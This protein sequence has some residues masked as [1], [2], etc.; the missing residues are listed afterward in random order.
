MS[1][2]MRV[3]GF[4]TVLVLAGSGAAFAQPGGFLSGTDITF[5]SGASVQPIYDGWTKNPDGSYQMHFGY[6]N[7]NYV[8]QPSVPIGAQNSIEPGGPDRGQPTFFYPRYNRRVFSLTVPRDFG[9]KGEVTWTLTVNGKTE[10]AVGWLQP[11]W[12][13]EAQSGRDPVMNAKNKPPSI[14]VAAPAGPVNAGASLTLTAK[15]T[16]DGLPPAGKTRVG[17]TSENPPAFRPENAGVAPTNVP[18][19]QRQR[20]PRING[21]SVSWRVFRGP[22]PVVFEPAAVAVKDGQ[23]VVNATFKTP[24][25]YVLRAVA[26]DTLATTPFDVKVVVTAAGGSAQGQQ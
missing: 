1:V 2:P 26:N 14:T 10:K 12:E 25:E 8:Q 13:I 3:V 5:N 20:V 17:G 16:D 21:L 22:G 9:I 6:Y 11:E 4:A 19:L 15:V 23:A 18:Q 24:G 7:R